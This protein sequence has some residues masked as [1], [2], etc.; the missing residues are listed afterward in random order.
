MAGGAATRKRRRGKRATR[1]QRTTR[2]Q[3]GGF[4]PSVMGNLLTT[5]PAFLTAAIAQGVRLLRNTETRMKSRRRQ[6]RK[7]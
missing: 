6:N 2:K 3:R 5:G 1:K 4:L 7:N